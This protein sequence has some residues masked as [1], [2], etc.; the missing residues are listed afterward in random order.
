MCARRVRV[1]VIFESVV[2]PLVKE[3]DR[4][5]VGRLYLVTEAEPLTQPQTQRER[6]REIERM[7]V[8]EVEMD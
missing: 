3:R 7:C 8:C 5:Q 4:Q 1:C 2:H 6:E